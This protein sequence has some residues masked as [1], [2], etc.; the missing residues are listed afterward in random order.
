MR[1]IQSARIR[2]LPAVNTDHHLSVQGILF[3]HINQLDRVHHHRAPTQRARF[4]SPTKRIRVI[5]KRDVVEARTVPVGPHPIPLLWD[6]R[7]HQ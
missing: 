5:H 3:V 6:D 4:E 1:S 7:F 2:I